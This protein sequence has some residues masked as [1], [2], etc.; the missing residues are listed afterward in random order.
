MIAFLLRSSVTSVDTA[1]DPSPGWALSG[2]RASGLR[3]QLDA[4]AAAPLYHLG[5]LHVDG[6]LMD[7]LPV[8]VKEFGADPRGRGLLRDGLRPR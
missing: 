8:G 3:F 2:R 5:T 4:G 7:N 6:G 1:S